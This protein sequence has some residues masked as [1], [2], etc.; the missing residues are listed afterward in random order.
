[1]VV[2]AQAAVNMSSANNFR[3]LID[4]N[5]KTAVF[6]PPCHAAAAGGRPAHAAGRQLQTRHRHAACM[7]ACHHALQVS[8]DCSC[9]DPT[10]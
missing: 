4:Y 8:T 7:G 3:V 10:C 5:T 9:G 6:S 2:Q 1:M